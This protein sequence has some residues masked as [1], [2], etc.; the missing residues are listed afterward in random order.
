MVVAFP[1]LGGVIMGANFVSGLLV[2]ILLSGLLLAIAMSNSGGAY[3]NAKKY[4]EAGA[5]GKL[6]FV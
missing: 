2:G 1:L 6:V 4:I 5:L 3:D